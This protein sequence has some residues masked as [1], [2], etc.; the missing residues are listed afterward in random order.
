MLVDIAV[1][2]AGLPQWALIGLAAWVLAIR[3]MER[4][5]SATGRDADPGA[6][7]HGRDACGL[8]LLTALGLVL[9][10]VDQSSGAVSS[11]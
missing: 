11:R 9:A 1:E 2:G 5:G 8:G 3:P 7:R 6:H 4:V 10:T